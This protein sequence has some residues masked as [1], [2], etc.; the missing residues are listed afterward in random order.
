[1]IELHQFTENDIKRLIS[2]IPGEAFLLQWAGPNYSYPLTQKQIQSTLE[3]TRGEHPA[4]YM[5]KAMLDDE[6]I[7]HIEL[8]AVD[9]TAAKAVLGR[10]LI[11]SETQRGQGYGL[12]MIQA[13]LKYAFEKLSMENIDLGVFKFNSAAINCYEKLGFKRYKSIP[14]RQDDNWTLLRMN[15]S[16]DN[17]NRQETTK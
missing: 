1:M 7:G 17:W 13:A 11:A 4:N 5:F 12:A 16:R 8:L 10:V 6:P 3:L 14:D 2:W 15:L 9:Y